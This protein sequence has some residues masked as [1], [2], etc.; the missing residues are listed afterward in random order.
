MLKP[1]GKKSKALASPHS[2]EEWHAQAL[3]RHASGSGGG[4]LLLTPHH[5]AL[6]IQLR[7]RVYKDKVR[8]LLKKTTDRARDDTTNGQS[9]ESV[10]T[11]VAGSVKA[12]VRERGVKGSS[13]ALAAAYKAR[14][15]GGVKE[16]EGE[17]Q[18]L[19]IKSGKPGYVN[20]A[21][22]VRPPIQDASTGWNA[23]EWTPPSKSFVS[24]STE[25][26]ENETEEEPDTTSL[27]VLGASADHVLSVVDG[28]AVLVRGR[29]K[30]FVNV[31]HSSW[32]LSSIEDR[33]AEAAASLGA[34]GLTGPHKQLTVV[35]IRHTVL[36]LLFILRSGVSENFHGRAPSP[37]ATHHKN[38]VQR[39]VRSQSEDGQAL[40]L[41]EEALRRVRRIFDS[42]K[43]D[44][45]MPAVRCLGWILTKTW[46]MLF[47]GMH[48]DVESLQRVREVLEASSPNVSVVFTPTHKTHLDYLII[49]YLCFAYGIP[50][51]R[52][53]AGNN[54]DL[55]LIG[56]F[57]RAN[58]SFFIRR[59]FKND[60]LYKQV[61]QQYVH[62]LMS[63]GNPI[64]V[65]VEGGRSRHG[66]VCKPRLGFLS[67]FL[68]YVKQQAADEGKEVLLVPISLDYDKVFEVEEY[69]N[70]LLGKPKEKESL[71]VFF[72]SVWDLLFLHCG[73][74]YVRFGEPVSMTA[75]TS[76]K[77][78][79]ETLAIRMQTSGTITSTSIVSAL[80][81][82][83]RAYTTRDMLVTRA[84]W[85]VDELESRGAVVAHLEDIDEL[86]NHALSVLNVDVEAQ[87]V[88]KSKLSFPTRALEMGFYR[89]H[90]LHVFLPDM[91]VMG[92]I[93]SLRLKHGDHE[94]SEV[95]L[96][97]GTV[98][99]TAESTWKFWRHIC[100][101]DT[102]DLA[103]HL[104][105]LV[106]RVPHV[107]VTLD[108]VT[109][110]VSKWRVTRIVSFAL[111]LHWS[112]MDSLWLAVL[113]SWH[114]KTVETC[115]ERDT[116][117]LA[118]WIARELFTR[119]QLQH[120]EAFCSESIKQAF[121]FL[122]E[123]EIL[124]FV[125]CATTGARLYKLAETSEVKLAELLEHV[126]GMRKPKTF[127]YRSDQVPASLLASEVLE[128]VHKAAK[129]AK[130]TNGR[131]RNGVYATWMS[132]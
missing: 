14:G 93:D 115:A 78:S 55:P 94:G 60:D 22:E 64:E 128:L 80:L 95:T 67:M 129:N 21:Q 101:H 58:G 9:S 76:L 113:A 124:N 106:L 32:L 36:D 51:P 120:A 53:A 35:D 46:R 116:V 34:R 119:G 102:V 103:Q 85:L 10:S 123:I 126:N 54:L 18:P 69:A 132:H 40:S 108:K 39:L 61:L 99:S 105:A 8:A 104:E 17:I 63:D 57:L 77:E 121:E 98:L 15:T 13:M 50:L 7:Y 28:E 38:L 59:S 111:S 88:I 3:Q 84:Q 114:L 30:N 49:S 122:R 127:L 19:V 100:R 5:A 25:D 130:E 47:S 29:P 70:Q 75:E 92:A 4:A 73:H 89:N 118:Q 24:Q 44:M 65:F 79:A 112:F 20:A 68:D 26:D 90:L 11:T 27:S 37:I 83:S 66:R 71:K 43:S 48:V 12:A 81:M 74:C 97:R 62:E 23:P 42:L 52:I 107:S 87:G 109:I 41:D 31:M 33:C 45:V 131:G 56:S 2:L 110:D 86:V 91:A 72:Q 117:R 16:S 125:S 6:R 1:M 96:D 82:W